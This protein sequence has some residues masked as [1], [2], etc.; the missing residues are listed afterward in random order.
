VVNEPFEKRNG[1][2]LAWIF[3]TFGIGAVLWF[4]L[5]FF[6]VERSPIVRQ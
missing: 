3:G 6:S 2:K 5:I 4:L 1:N